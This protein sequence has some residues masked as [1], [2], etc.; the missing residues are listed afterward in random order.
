MREEKNQVTEL[1]KLKRHETPGDQ[2][3]DAFLDE[4]HRY[5][6]AEMLPT[7][8]SAGERVLAFCRDI[9]AWFKPQPQLAWS[10]LAA[11]VVLLSVV[12]YQNSL[13][14]AAVEFAQV[15]EA[16]AFVDGHTVYEENGSLPAEIVVADYNSFEREFSGSHFVTGDNPSSYDSVLAF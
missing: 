3:F 14:D 8:R 16:E 9:T 1:L 11:I 15:N 12:S 2:Y 13:P 6:R 5:Q 4:F 7:R 10:S